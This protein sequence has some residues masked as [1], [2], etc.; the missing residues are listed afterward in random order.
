[1]N[2]RIRRRRFGHIALATAAATAL[3]NL[4][5]K[6]IGHQT[7]VILGLSLGPNNTVGSNSLVGDA[8]S[9]TPALSLILANLQTGQQL[10]ILQ[11]PPNNVE[12][13]PQFSQDI[14]ALFANQTNQAVSIASRERLTGLTTLTDGTVIAISVINS[15]KGPV[16]RLVVTDTKSNQAQTSLIVSGLPNNNSTVEDLVA[17]KDG[18]L[19]AV[20]S[21]NG[22]TPPFQLVTIDRTSGA[23]NSGNNSGLPDVPPFL[24]ISNL[25]QSTDGTIY[26]T[27]LGRQGVTTL[28]QLDCHKANII[29]LSPLM[30]NNKPLQNDLLS[31]AISPDKQ[32]FALADPESQKNNVLHNVNLNTGELEEVRPFAVDQIAIPRS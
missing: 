10:S 22:G 3:A 25:A 28:V 24:R 29:N 27:T 4:G 15:D 13:L 19:L 23:V 7:P 9:A 20:V 30:L 11:I 17:T 12:N 2:F 1:M 21:L 6:A 18:I 26:A 14:A 32:L 31:L 5:G 16:S 8:A